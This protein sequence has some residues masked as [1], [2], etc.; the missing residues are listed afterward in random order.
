M[1]V[2]LLGG[3]GAIGNYLIDQLIKAGYNVTVTSR[4]ERLSNKSNL[5]FIQGNAKDLS[6]IQTLD[7]NWDDIVDFMSYQT[8]EFQ[9]NYLTLLNLTR[10]YVFLSSARVYADSKTPIVEDSLR[11]LDASKDKEYL[12]TDDYS[13]AKA[14]QENILRDSGHKNYSIVRPYITYG[15][16]RLQLGVLEKEEWLYRAMQGRTIIFCKDIEDKYT[17]MTSGYDVANCIL[18]II[19]TCANG[20]SYNLTNNYRITWGSIFDVYKKAIFDGL[21]RHVLVHYIS[22]DEFINLFRPEKEKYQITVDR[23][24]NRFFDN[25][26]IAKLIDVNSFIHPEKALYACTS[27]F[28]HAPRFK[29]INWQKEANNDRITNEWAS[30]KDIHEVKSII[31]LGY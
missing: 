24:Y 23:V 25:S 20:E 7:S 16:Y 2:L 31:R 26:K 10:H 19:A 6:F 3:T 14:R 27:E 18:S 15:T 12:A 5:S 28:L 4:S 1:K 17:T 8:D 29:G 11:L 13:L 9:Q 30:I 21:K 22:L